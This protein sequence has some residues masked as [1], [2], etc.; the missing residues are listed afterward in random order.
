MCREM[1]R[2]PAWVSAIR[3]AMLT[4]R[5]TVSGVVEEA[6][7]IDG[8]ERTVEDVLETMC[9][10]DLLAA[11]DDGAYVPG[12][13]LLESDRFDLKFENASDGGAHRWNSSV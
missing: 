1:R 2:E 5:V 12:S 3:L 7:L 9:D 6:N 11:A 8:R 13:V 4:G 10:R